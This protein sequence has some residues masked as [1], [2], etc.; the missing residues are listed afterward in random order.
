MHRQKLRAM[1]SCVDFRQPKSLSVSKKSARGKQ[2]Q[3]LEGKAPDAQTGT[4]R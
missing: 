4:T 2:A 3:L 1:K